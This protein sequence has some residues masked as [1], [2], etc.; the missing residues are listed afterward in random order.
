MDPQPGFTANEMSAAC[1]SYP[2][3]CSHSKPPLPHHTH[4]LILFTMLFWDFGDRM[5]V[6]AAASASRESL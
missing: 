3:P 4:V 6:S 5:L 2:G 1:L